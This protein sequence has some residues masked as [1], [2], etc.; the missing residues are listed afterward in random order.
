MPE[1]LK[2]ILKCSD[3]AEKVQGETGL[4][5][6]AGKEVLRNDGDRLKGH[7]RHLEEF[8][9]TKAGIM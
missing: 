6:P 8:P 7:K 1:L 4:R 2:E 5:V 9:M 3:G